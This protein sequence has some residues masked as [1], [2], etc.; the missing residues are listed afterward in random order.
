MLLWYSVVLSSGVVEFSVEVSFASMFG[1]YSIVASESSVIGIVCGGA[2][3][4][5]VG[6]CEVLEGGSVVELEDDEDDVGL[7][8]CFVGF[9]GEVGFG[10]ASSRCRLWCLSSK[11]LSSSC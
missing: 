10:I 3:C 11:S 4:S 6:C 7:C 2:F 5:V 1:G 8:C 9:V